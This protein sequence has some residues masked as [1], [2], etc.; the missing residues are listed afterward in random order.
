MAGGG[1]QVKGRTSKR[2]GGARKGATKGRPPRRRPAVG[3]SAWIERT[4][5]AVAVA[6]GLVLAFYAVRSLVAGI[7]ESCR[8]EER[9]V[10]LLATG[11]CNCG[12]CCGWRLDESGQPVYDYGPMRGM[13]KDVGRTSTGAVARPGTIAADPK[14][15]R[16]GTC[17]YVPGYGMGRVEDVGGAIK[18]AHIDLWF[19][20]HE[21]ARRWGA[22]RL[23]V[24]VVE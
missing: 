2:R 1:R 18:G 17:L 22:R 16:A 21:E 10:E 5:A 15:F 9:W 6:A 13:P 19:P 4:V 11:Y 14:V 12:E 3:R 23:R 7:R 20:S 24:R 8:P